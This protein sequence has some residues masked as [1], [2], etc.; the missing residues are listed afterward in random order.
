MN[1]TPD[2]LKAFR[3]FCF[4]GRTLSFVFLSVFL[5]LV[6]L[7]LPYRDYKKG[8]AMPGKVTLYRQWSVTILGVVG[9]FINHY[10]LSL[11]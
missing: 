2:T 9:P 1:S 3:E 4:I 6:K 8:H 7:N 5:N 10:I 11:D